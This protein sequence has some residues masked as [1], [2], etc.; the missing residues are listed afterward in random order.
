MQ[1]SVYCLVGWS[2]LSVIEEMCTKAREEKG[3]RESERKS[4]CV[5]ELRIVCKRERN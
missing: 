2:N 4:R 1:V 5:C 3:S